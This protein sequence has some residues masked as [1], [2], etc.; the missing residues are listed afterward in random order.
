M[1]LLNYPYLF[2]PINPCFPYPFSSPTVL[3]LSLCFSRYLLSLL[4]SSSFFGPILDLRP[5]LCTFLLPKHCIL[6]ACV[7]SYMYNPIFEKPISGLRWFPEFA[8]LLDELLR[9]YAFKCGIEWN[10]WL[11]TWIGP[12]EFYRRRWVPA[13]R[14]C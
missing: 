6:I 2:L 1:K 14:W 4:F 7:Y 11:E 10:S 5:N 13:S 3:E 12:S 8:S 9:A